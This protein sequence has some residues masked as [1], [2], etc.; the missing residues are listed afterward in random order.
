MKTRAILFCLAGGLFGGCAHS[1]MDE[2]HGGMRSTIAANFESAYDS[3][4]S[5]AKSTARFGGYVIDSAGQ[6]M[7][8]VYRE[9]R[10]GVAGEGS[11]VSDAYITAKIKSKLATDGDVKSGD[12]KVDTD[13]GVVTLRGEVRTEH[14]AA[15]AIQD[16]LDTGGVFAVNSE[17][18]WQAM[19]TTG[20]TASGGTVRGGTM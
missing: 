2:E 1:N 8:R 15:K 17:L 12:V 18:T 14:E 7:V 11:S 3:V 4:K 5:G 20:N 19:P 6:G 9:A 13:A 16:A 10:N